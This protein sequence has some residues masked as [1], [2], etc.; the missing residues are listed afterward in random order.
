MKLETEKAPYKQ[1]THEI[2][3]PLNGRS[4]AITVIGTIFLLLLANWAVLW[5]IQEYPRNRGYWL[6]R[7]KWELLHELAAP[8]DWLIV[9]DSTG[10]Q[11]LVPEVLEEQLGGTAV[12]L[13][14]VG[15]MGAVD[16]VWMLE[17]YIERFGPPAHVLV[18]HSYD[19]WRRDV[20]PVFVAK[21]PLPWNSWQ[22]KYVP[23]LSLTNE[24]Q[25][26]LWLVRYF[27]LYAE[28]KS[29]GEIIKE[30]IY[31]QR[32]IFQ[33]RFNLQD[34]GY[35]PLMTVPASSLFRQDV[36]NHINFVANSSFV[37]SDINQQALTQLINLADTHDIDVYL[38]FGPLFE[39]VA[40]NEA[41]QT[42]YGQVR[43]ELQA[44]ADRSENLH[45]LPEIFTFPADQM[46]NVDH[47]IFEA[48]KAYTSLIA[49]A[50]EEVQ[51]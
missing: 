45:L 47:V 19:V 3:Q 38:A 15:N 39:E 20:K 25:F 43:T 23:S 18:I 33:K 31:A 34:N 35:M 40:A 2:I 5:Y 51:K 13:N 16:D 30:W 8:V 26:N 48:A 21:T 49:S 27:P 32:P 17:E 36:Q 37:M 14:T 24:E 7:Q 11:G 28:N 42:Y 10:N 44:F 22:N 46:E 6:V 1:L 29:L 9:G 50:V 4:A 41:F 12:N